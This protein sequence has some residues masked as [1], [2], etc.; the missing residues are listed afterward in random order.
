MPKVGADKA[1][2]E[3]LSAVDPDFVPTDAVPKN[4]EK[5][6]GQ[7]QAGES[8]EGPSSSAEL[9]V[10]EM[11]G[12]EFKVEPLRR[13]GEDVNTMRARLLCPSFH[14]VLWGRTTFEQMDADWICVEYPTTD[15]ARKRGTLESDLLLSTFADAN[16]AKM[17]STQLQQ[18]D[19]FMDENDW[20][21]YY[22]ATQ[23][24]TQTS[25]ET[26][27]GG[28]LEYA[29]P[30]VARKIVPAAPAPAPAASPS[31]ARDEDKKSQDPDAW[32]QGQ[33]PSGE[34]APTVGTFKPAY[35]PVPR[36]WRHSEILAMLRRHVVERSASGLVHHDDGTT[37][38]GTSIGT[39]GSKR[40]GLGRMPEV[41][42]FDL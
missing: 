14:N 32:R 25:R 22:W 8:D 17:S 35:R 30:M 1:P 11:E 31:T 39:N 3:L 18:F 28:S 2:P 34:W 23:A 29:E 10:G 9:G 15:Q 37:D 26:A 20:D 41:K 27:E 7:T 42:N 33:A 5:M 19:L 13:T 24:P 4:T 12:A 16:L 40:S 6:T 36:R 21:I 38:P